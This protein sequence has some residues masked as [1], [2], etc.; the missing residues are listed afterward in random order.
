M[1]LITVEI[2]VVGQHLSEF[3]EA[4]HRQASNSM[5]LEPDCHRFE[6]AVSEDNANLVF[7]YEIYT[8]RAAFDQHL[9]SEHFA[10]FDRT[11][12]TWVEDKQVK[13][14]KISP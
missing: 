2:R 6:V 5:N 8:D 13:C 3:M 7:L 10:D 1:Y 9:A 4:M 12:S 14:W 11:V